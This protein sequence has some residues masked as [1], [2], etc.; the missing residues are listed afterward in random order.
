VKVIVDTEACT[1]HGR[2]AATA[3]EVFTLD[4]EGRNSVRE[5]E[6]PAGLEAA[7]RRGAANCPERC[8]SVVD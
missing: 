7:A 2:C 3:P 4:D 5:L 1:G 6:V 8:I